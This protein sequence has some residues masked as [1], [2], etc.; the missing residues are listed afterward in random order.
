MFY[1]YLELFIIFVNI[2][3]YFIILLI[4][5][6]KNICIYIKNSMVFEILKNI[7]WNYAKEPKKL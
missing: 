7:L 1:I 5:I 2:N 6:N 3:K 4:L